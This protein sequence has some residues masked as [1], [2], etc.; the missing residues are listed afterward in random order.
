MEKY[1]VFG[2]E[3]TGVHPFIPVA[4]MKAQVSP[5]PTSF[6]ARVAAAGVSLVSL[7]L[8]NFLVGLRLLLLLS[9]ALLAITLQQILLV[10]SPLPSLHWILSLWV[11]ALP[12]RVALLALG[13]WRLD[14]QSADFRRLKIRA[15]P[16]NAPAPW[17]TFLALPASPTLPAGASSEAKRIRSC[18]VCLSNFTGLV[19]PLYLFYRLAPQFVLLHEQ[20][21]FSFCSVWAML[22][23]SMQFRLAPGKGAFRSLSALLLAHQKSSSSRIPLVI[24]P[25]GQKSNGTCI[26]QW[27]AAGAAAGKGERESL[28]S[29]FDTAAL[30]LLDGRIAE[31]GCLYTALATGGRAGSPARGSVPYG[32]PHTVHSPLRH[33]RLSLAERSHAVAPIWASPAAVQASVQLQSRG[34]SAAPPEAVECLREVMIRMLPG[35]TGVQTKGGADLQAFNAYWE[36]TQKEQYLKSQ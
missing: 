13:V 14:E 10:F 29:G 26:L 6:V 5:P 16:P 18:R 20:G 22:K 32:P 19:E 17:S 1:R 4:Y 31:V 35:V 36:K 11:L 12:A 15:P 30:Q 28:S 24:F 9:A 23:F 21:G 3:S 33:L 7:L 27:T 2:D 25:E 8:T 34:A